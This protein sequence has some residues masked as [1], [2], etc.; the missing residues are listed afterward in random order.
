MPVYRLT[1]EILFPPVEFA[2]PGGLLAIGGD[3]SPER[4]ARLRA[5]WYCLSVRAAGLILKRAGWHAPSE[6]E[7]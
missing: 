4:L 2:E 5:L 6:P 1:D 3:L 7:L